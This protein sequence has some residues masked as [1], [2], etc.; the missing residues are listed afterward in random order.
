MPW[1]MK[2]AFTF[3][4]PLL[5][6]AYYPAAA[7]CGWGVPYVTGWLALPAGTVFLLISIVIWKFGV[8]HYQSTGS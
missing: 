8:R 6:I 4:M 7:A 3:I 1:I 5:V 2:N